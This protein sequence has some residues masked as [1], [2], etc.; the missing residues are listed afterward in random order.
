MDNNIRLKT[1]QDYEAVK[2]TGSELAIMEFVKALIEEYKSTEEYKIA[3][4]AEAYDKQ[5]N[6]FMKNYKKYIVLET[7]ETVEDKYSPNHKV[8]S[9]FYHQFTTQLANYVLSNGVSFEKKSTKDKLG[10]DFDEKIIELAIKAM[11]GKRA[12]GFFN[13]DHLEVFSNYKSTDNAVFIAL[14]DEETGILR[15]GVRFWQIDDYKPMY[16]TLYDEQDYITYVFKPNKE[17]QIRYDRQP[18]IKNYSRM[19]GETTY[20]IGNIQ[21]TIPIFT[22]W[23]NGIHTSEIEGMKETIDLYDLT[24]NANGNDLDSAMLYWLV[25]GGE[26]MN[27]KELVRFLKQLQSQRVASVDNDRAVEPV[28]VSPPTEARERLLAMLERRLYDDFGML[29]VTSLSAG[30]VTATQITAAYE[31]MDLKASALELQITKFIRQL[32][33]YLNIDDTPTYTRSRLINRMETV[34]ILGMLE[35]LLTKEYRTRK[36]LEMLDDGDKAE[37][38]IVQKEK[39]DE[40]S[41]ISMYLNQQ[42]ELKD[43]Q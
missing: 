10:K 32:L 18:Y 22:M 29:D 27:Q 14:D 19:Y 16:A 33:A 42:E 41:E 34:N 11:H 15:A 38:M 5:Q 37:E 26:G 7:G 25:H 13:K 24:L 8:C 9:N 1:F 31:K 43:N 4:T 2:N 21:S 3:Q 20:T 23:G 12:Y 30:N 28:T 40:D 17:S 6:T 36:G 39:E 35:P